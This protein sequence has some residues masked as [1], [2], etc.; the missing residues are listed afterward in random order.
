MNRLSNSQLGRHWNVNGSA[1]ISCDYSH[2]EYDLCRVNGSTLFDPASS[3]IYA[4]G[5][6]TQNQSHVP[7]KIRPYPLKSDKLAMAA[8]KELNLTEAPTKLSCG[9]THRT[10][11][12]V[13]SA[14]GYTGN[15]YHEIN[16]NFIPL[17]ITITSLFPN[18]DV[19]L[20]V[21][22]GK[23]WWFQ[24]YGELL[25]ALSPLH[26]IINAN[27]LSTVHC[28]PSATI[29]LMKHGP[30]MIDPKLLPNP[31]TLF[32][33][34]AFLGK[35]YTEIG[36]PFMQPNE[37][38][39]PRLTLISRRRGVSRVILNEEDVIKVGEEIGFNVHVFEPS[40][41]TPMAQVYGV[42]HSSEVLLGVH[43]AGLTNFLLMKPGSVLVQVVPFHLEWVSETYYK[44]PP[45]KLG[46]EYVEY[47]IELNESSLL[48]KYGADSL[49]IKDPAAF[50]SKYSHK[51]V[52]WTEQNVRID[53]IRFR[54][55]LIKAYEKAKI[56]M[57]KVH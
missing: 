54:S 52:Y 27:N 9:V 47:K 2:D 45:I 22:E 23:S 16:E 48:E 41:S 26:S 44:K 46:L 56:F 5:P 4:M 43:G 38:G 42:V 40:T 13:F 1:V 17:F 10:P 14:A 7:V 29:G 30:M 12:L 18:Q 51:R 55:C 33:F 53:I 3:T 6:H 37:N 36:T 57:S 49:V 21:T 15:Y 20:L 8:V 24:K 35:V 50:Q 31:K 25:S 39:K 19:T 34:R 32:D 28:F 11:A